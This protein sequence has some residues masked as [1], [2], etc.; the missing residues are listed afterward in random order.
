M[1]NKGGART[2]IVSGVADISDPKQLQ[3][4]SLRLLAFAR[5]RAAVRRW[6]LGAAGGLAKGQTVED[7]VCEAVESL[8]G[9]KRRW[10]PASQP[11][12]WEHLKSVV[13]SLLSN[14]VRSKENRLNSRDVP[15]DAVAPQDT[16]ESALL[17]SEEEG[18]L[19]KRRE[20]AYSLLV[21][22]IADADDKKLLA[23]HDLI[24]NENI[25]KPQELSKRLSIPVAEVNNLKKR[26]WR[27]CRRVLDILDKEEG[28]SHD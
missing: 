1:E 28:Q 6:W 13:N 7:V 26:F 20:R 10:D 25:H 24:M 17:R 5:R 27:A 3:G 19:E 22:Q 23:L 9:G 11:D 12:P 15:Q 14:L 18:A 8:F 21:D 4:L 2:G 16:P